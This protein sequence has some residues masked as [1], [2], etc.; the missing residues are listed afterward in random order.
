MLSEKRHVTVILRLVLDAGGRLEHGELVEAQGTLWGRLVG[1]RGAGCAA[2]SAVHY[3]GTLVTH[4]GYRRPSTH[5]SA[6][7]TIDAEAR[8]SPAVE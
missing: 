6:R 4:M 8:R 7:V 3:V 5:G 2:P 1:R